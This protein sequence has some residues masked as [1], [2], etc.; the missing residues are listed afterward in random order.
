MYVNGVMNELMHDLNKIGG[1]LPQPGLPFLILMIIVDIS[2]SSIGGR[3]M[4][5]SMLEERQDIGLVPF[6]SY[7]PILVLFS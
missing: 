1:K 4:L 5:F 7:L 2:S 3:N 6:L